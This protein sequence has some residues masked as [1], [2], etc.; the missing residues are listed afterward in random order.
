MTNQTQQLIGKEI[1]KIEST[2]KARVKS[3]EAGWLKGM[4]NVNFEDG[5]TAGFKDE[6]LASLLLDGT[7][8]SLGV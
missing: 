6:D 4:F 2:K 5:T 1:F 7:T 8:K 3:V